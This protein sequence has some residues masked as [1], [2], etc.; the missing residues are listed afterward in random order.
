MPVLSGNFTWRLWMWQEV[1]WKQRV[2]VPVENL[3]KW[4][5]VQCRFLLGFLGSSEFAQQQLK[6]A[7]IK[8][9]LG[10]IIRLRKV[11]WRYSFHYLVQKSGWNRPAYLFCIQ[12]KYLFLFFYYFKRIYCWFN[13]T[14]VML[15]NR[16][17]QF[18]SLHEHSGI[19]DLR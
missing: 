19:K 8:I 5:V 17:I 15:K 2:E 11:I 7:K 9:K 10:R 13:A 16:R 4:K 6:K 14:Y 12:N 1:W 18:L 3:P